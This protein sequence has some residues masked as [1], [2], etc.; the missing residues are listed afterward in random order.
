MFWQRF[1]EFLAMHCMSFSHVAQNPA[2]Q[3]SPGTQFHDFLHTPP[4]GFCKSIDICCSCST[5]GYICQDLEAIRTAIPPFGARSP[6]FPECKEFFPIYHLQ[7]QVAHRRLVIDAR[8]HELRSLRVPYRSARHLLSKDG[9][10][11]AMLRQAR[12]GKRLRNRQPRGIPGETLWVLRA[13]PRQHMH[14]T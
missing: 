14:A 4:S 6:S 10:E 8:L 9:R 13:A 7:H 3:T 12:M 5:H 2:R 11:A 1:F